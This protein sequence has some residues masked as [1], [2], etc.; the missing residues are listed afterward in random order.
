MTATRFSWLPNAELSLGYDQGDLVDYLESVGDDVWT[1]TT[2][3]ANGG[4]GFLLADDVSQF[5]FDRVLGV[6]QFKEVVNTGH[7]QALRYVY[8]N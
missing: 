6:G 1:C 8:I 5:S 7:T 3:V 4:N 2:L